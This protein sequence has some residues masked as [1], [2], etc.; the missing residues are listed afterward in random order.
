MDITNANIKLM[1][2]NTVTIEGINITYYNNSVIADTTL[3]FIHGNSLDSG[4]F[5]HQFQDEALQKYRLIAID[6]PGH[7]ESSPAPDPDNTY[8]VI[9][10][11]NIIEKFIKTLKFDRVVLIGH[12]LGGHIAIEAVE[13]L[14]NVAGLVIF[15]TPPIGMPPAMEEMFLPNE[16]MGFAI[17]SE[18]KDDEADMLSSSFTSGENTLKSCIQNTD[19]DARAFMGASI[20]QGKFRNEVEIC[21]GLDLP[22]SVFHGE[23]DALVNL[24]YLNKLTLPTLWENKIHFLH[25]S[26]HSPQLENPGAF[27]ELLIR[28]LDAL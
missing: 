5:K 1:R 2:K 4:T 12:S 7:G 25:D 13:E 3:L 26:G 27:N 16:A 22:L 15:G 9:G 10:Y 24:E 6:L 21:A 23:D 19:P 20:A 8:N 28:F 17:T 11:A 14:S 18:L